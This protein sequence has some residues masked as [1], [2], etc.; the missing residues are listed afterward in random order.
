MSAFHLK[1][2]WVVRYQ[3]TFRPMQARIK[4]AGGKGGTLRSL[5]ARVQCPTALK[6]LLICEFRLLTALTT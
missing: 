1:G 5:E 3:R 2:H 6:R 4:A